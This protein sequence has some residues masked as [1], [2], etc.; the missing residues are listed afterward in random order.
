MDPLLNILKRLSECNVEYVLIGG[1]AAIAHGANVVTHDVDVCT[2]F[3]D[4]N[5][6]RILEAVTPLD[7]RLRHRPDKMRLPL[8][9]ERLQGLKNLYLD[10]TLGKLDLLGEVPEVATYAEVVSRAV[11]MDVGGLVCRVIDID[12]LMAAKRV[13]N[14]ERDHTALRHL[15]AVKKR[16]E[17]SG[18][19]CS[20][21]EQRAI[22]ER[23]GRDLEEMQAQCESMQ[24]NWWRQLLGHRLEE[25]QQS[26]ETAL[27]CLNDPDPNIRRGV[28]AL[29]AS[30]W[31][32][33]PAQDDLYRRIISSDPHMGARAAAVSCL[34]TLHSGSSHQDVC[35]LLA[36]LVKDE[37]NSRDLRAVAYRGLFKIQ[38][39]EIT[40]KLSLAL[41]NC[42]NGLPEEVDWAFVDSFLV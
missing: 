27:R 1:M 18:V 40:H 37:S 9:P 29:L 6:R 13:A 24:H 41:L 20:K 28:L 4:V 14:R 16:R 11:E 32:P 36:G 31:P 38:G 30:Y 8:D 42:E 15:A 7:P 21:D 33:D 17:E 12:T 19:N 35:K 26:R 5:L 2:T 3:D 25:I 23:I 10:T 22:L 39:L 34:S